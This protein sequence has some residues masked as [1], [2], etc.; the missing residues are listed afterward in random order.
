M[1][2]T[3]L[4]QSRPLITCMLQT[5]TAMDAICT[6]RNA[7][8]DGCDAFG[9]QME[10]MKPE[11]Q[12]EEKL[13][14]IFR[15]TAG[16]PIYATNY[17]GHQNGDMPDEEL[18]EGLMLLLKCGATLLDVMGDYYSPHPI[19]LT[20]DAEAVEKQKAL[21]ER[22]HAAGGEVLM[23]SHVLKFIPEEE[24]MRIALAHKERGA[25]ICKIVTASNSDEEQLENLKIINT[26]KKELGIPFL[27]LAGGSHCKL[28]RTIGPMLGCT[29]WLT[30]HE[31][32]ALSTRAQ[33]HCRAIRTI[34][35][36]F[37]YLPERSL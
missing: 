26:L 13:K 15:L 32:N 8:Y 16:K 10:A 28:I 19:Q 35:D 34:L 12:T 6:V 33:P 25:D 11:E 29:M 21:I 17:R 31:Y 24:V 7:M 37:D 3:F 9:F 2:P 1:K 14:S 20:E 36:N 23:S 22:I 18:A 4:G 30:V 27:F 5:R